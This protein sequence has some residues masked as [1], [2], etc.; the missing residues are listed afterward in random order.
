MPIFFINSNISY[1]VLII[2]SFVSTVNDE[3]VQRFYIYLKKK[4]KK[5]ATTLQCSTFSHSLA[6][7][8]YDYIITTRTGLLNFMRYATFLTSDR[9]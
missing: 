9:H 5:N 7:G 8:L 2:I 1:V 4:K 3:A 6:Y